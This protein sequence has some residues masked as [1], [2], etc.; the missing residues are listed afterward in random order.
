MRRFGLPALLATLV[1]AAAARAADLGPAPRDADGRFLN[2]AGAIAHAGPL[3]T[4]PFFL[5]R[6]G[7][8]LFG[9]A[10]VLARHENDGAFLRAN[11]GHSVPT[12]TWVGHSTLL[13]QM[14][15]A[16]FLTD[17]IWSATASPVAPLGPR[18]FVA[19][20]ISLEALPPIDFVLVSHG[21]Y[22]HLDVDTLGALAARSP[23]TRFYVPLGNG[24]LLRDRGI[25]RVRELDWGERVADGA[26]TVHC[27]P[28]Q[29]WSRRGLRDGRR[30]LWASWAVVSP[31]RRFY[32]AG[33]S[34][35][36]ADFAAIG[37]ALGPF[38]L[39]ALPI[40]AYSPPAMMRPWHL[41]PEEAVRAGRDLAARRLVAVHFGTFDL[42][43][44]PLDEPPRRF[45]DAAE[46]AGLAP[47]EAWVLA[48][49]ETR[50][51]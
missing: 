40:G 28:A 35:Y 26:V 2:R 11:A 10:G 39:A 34:G 8:T 31:E 16:T 21:H 29:H 3:V 46:R 38:D 1:L 51:F 9:R 6:A 33:D 19:P 25:E 24:P 23:A 30:T 17:P 43:D 18:R 48:V 7:T 5:R 12:A 45:R 14:G 44:E 20:G 4:W 13:V 47:G 42:S 37:A 27:L 36:S 50:D 41:D 22:D 32:F 15:H 49:G